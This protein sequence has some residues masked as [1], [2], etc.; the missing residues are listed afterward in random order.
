MTV[1]RTCTLGADSLLALCS[2]THW[3]V[4]P[5]CSTARLLLLCR[6]RE[7]VSEESVSVHVCIFLFDILLL[8]GENL[9]K[10]SFRERRRALSRLFTALKPGHVELARSF[11]LRTL[12]EE[13]SEPQN[14]EP[15]PSAVQP[16]EG[17][18][19]A[20]NLD[21]SSAAPSTEVKTMTVR[22]SSYACSSLHIAG[23]LTTN[24]HDIGCE[25]R[26]D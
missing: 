17:N 22:T 24:P 13:G 5:P 15:P 12:T 16:E 19:E 20:G 7:S 18:P 9:L 26:F 3:I 8:E 6:A 11:E 21:H 4:K 2:G 1:P 10:K 23:V 25:S 14:A